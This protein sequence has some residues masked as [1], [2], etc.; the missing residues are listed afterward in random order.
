[1]QKIQVLNRNAARIVSYNAVFPVCRL[2][3]PSLLTKIQKQHRCLK[4]NRCLQP[5]D[6]QAIDLFLPRRFRCPKHCH[7][8]RQKDAKWTRR[9][10]SGS[11]FPRPICIHT[12]NHKRLLQGK[13]KQNPRQLLWKVTPVFFESSEPKKIP[14]VSILQAKIP[15]N[16]LPLTSFPR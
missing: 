4:E 2:M 3:L 16:Q 8:R 15:P 12:A 9:S 10:H 1:M 11:K 5:G 13:R 14:Q 7:N 6:I